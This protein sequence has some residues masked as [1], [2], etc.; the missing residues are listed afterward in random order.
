[1]GIGLPDI[2]AFVGSEQF[3]PM[4]KLFGLFK[5]MMGENYPV[6]TFVMDKLATQMRAAR[7]VFDCDDVYGQMNAPHEEVYAPPGRTY[8][9]IHMTNATQL[10]IP[11]IVD[12]FPG[13][14]GRAGS[15]QLERSPKDPAGWSDVA[16]SRPLKV[17]IQS[18]AR[19]RRFPAVPLT[20]LIQSLD[21]LCHRRLQ[22]PSDRDHNSTGRIIQRHVNLSIL[23]EELCEFKRPKKRRIK[24]ERKYGALFS[25]KS[26]QG[27]ISAQ[28]LHRA[29]G[30]D[31]ILPNLF[32]D[33][34]EFSS[35]CLSGLFPSTW[36]KETDSD[37]GNVPCA[38]K[39]H[40]NVPELA[41]SEHARYNS[42][43]IL[44]SCGEF[45][46]PHLRRNVRV[47]LSVL[48]ARIR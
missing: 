48:I 9:L 45:Y 6:R 26:M 11:S 44:G 43:Q 35:Q 13:G 18:I 31:D 14:N 3:S 25:L 47:P 20:N 33:C 1:M 29:A 39:M 41:V 27:Y 40:S 12:L 7:I 32:T 22:S 5:E 4:R 10:L 30:P 46:V 21:H 8:V 24:V 15:G 38:F 17:D 2:Y 19:V 23:T 42:K 28:K 34:V 36:E 37:S 16:Y